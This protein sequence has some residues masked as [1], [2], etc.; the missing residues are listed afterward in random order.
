MALELVER[1]QPLGFEDDR[2]AR[3]VVDGAA[4]QETAGVL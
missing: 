4:G 3:R 1:M 2:T